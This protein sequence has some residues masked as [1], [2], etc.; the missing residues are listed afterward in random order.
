MSEFINTEDFAKQ[1]DATDALASFRNEFAFPQH[2]NENVVYFTGNSLGLLPHAARTAVEQEFNDWQTY[3]VEGHFLA[4]S[5]WYSYHKQFAPA[6][7]SLTGALPSEVVAMNSL[8]VNVHLM[9]S[10]F[11]QPTKERNIILL[12]GQEFPSDRY[13]AQSQVQ[14]HG[15]SHNDCIVELMPRDGE[16]TLRTDDICATIE[17]LG[18][19]LALVHLSAVHYYTGQYYDIPAITTAAHAT[20][21]YIGWD[22]AHAIGNVPLHL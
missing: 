19:R 5:P 21:A 10:S 14:A 20:G 12:L 8:T 11:Y 7:A 15:Y 9:M 4:A 13:A 6:L 18:N 2:H 1:C 16:H 22:L 3:G 17:R